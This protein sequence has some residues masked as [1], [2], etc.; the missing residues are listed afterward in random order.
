MPLVQ[1]ERAVAE[2]R[3]GCEVVGDQDDCFPLAAELVHAVHASVLENQITH[4]QSLIRQQD[5]GV[6]VNGNRERQAHEHS[7]G[8]GLDRLVH[9][10]SD[11]REAS[12]GVEALF[13]GGRIETQDGPVHEN[14]L[15]P[16]E[17]GIEAATQFQERRD[18]AA[19]QAVAARLPHDSSQNLQQRALARAVLPDDA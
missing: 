16:R 7:A 9:E 13:H 6:H 14:I 5:I 1:E 18:F 11:L 4:S 8:V 2:S 12:D 3:Y 10:I 19:H 15:P 17:L